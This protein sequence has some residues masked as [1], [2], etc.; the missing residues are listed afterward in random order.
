M[1]GT[2]KFLLIGADVTERV[3][4]DGQEGLEDRLLDVVDHVDVG[5]H[6]R[7]KGL[8]TPGL[9]HHAVTALV[10]ET[11]LVAVVR[12]CTVDRNHTLFVIDD[13]F[14]FPT[15]VDAG[16]LSY[17]V[18]DGS[19][20]DGDD[21]L[22]IHHGDGGKILTY[23]SFDVVYKYLYSGT[24]LRTKKMKREGTGTHQRDQ[25][26]NHVVEVGALHDG[27]DLPGLRGRTGA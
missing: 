2:Q 21:R 1:D 20:S 18:R 11:K 5:S 19:Y 26:G 14:E 24:Q 16:P 8:T 6:V 4:T 9:N 3:G 27:L 23:G 15:M 13:T 7:R 22:R 12:K 25:L 10:I 17:L